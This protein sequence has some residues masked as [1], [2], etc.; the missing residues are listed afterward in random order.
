MFH[1]SLLS[2]GLQGLSTSDH[3]A[4]SPPRASQPSLTITSDCV[5]QE[6][7][8]RLKPSL[9]ITSDCVDQESYARLKGALHKLMNGLDNRRQANKRPED[10]HVSGV[11]VK[12]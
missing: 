11:H 6:S 10:L 5:D 8:A 1:A 7:Y 3:D 4:S 12:Y 9:T 2:I